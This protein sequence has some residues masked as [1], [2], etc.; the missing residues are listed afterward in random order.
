MTEKLELA[1][2]E[3]TPALTEWWV[4]RLVLDWDE[5]R[6]DVVLRGTN[7]ERA[8]FVLV[9]AAER[10]KA[11]N[12]ADPANSLHRMALDWLVADG[13]VAGAVTG[14]AELP[15]KALAL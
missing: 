3:V 15:L 6:I 10:L 13:K 1:T 14:I 7:G 2:P 8:T 5:A 4:S 9:D 11:M 12:A